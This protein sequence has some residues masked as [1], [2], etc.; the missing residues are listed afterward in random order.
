[1]ANTFYTDVQYFEDALVSF[2]DKLAPISALST[3]FEGEIQGASVIVPLASTG[4]GQEFAGTYA[5]DNSTLAEI[6][7]PVK[8]VFKSF[9]INVGDASK[10]AAASLKNLYKTNLD[11][12]MAAIQ[13]T[14]FADVSNFTAEEEFTTGAF[15]WADVKAA[16]T[17][18]ADLP[19][20]GKVL[21]LKSALNTQL[22]PNADDNIVVKA[23]DYDLSKFVSS[24]LPVDGVLTHA[25]TYAVATALPS[26]PLVG[27]TALIDSE[28]IEV[29]GM[30]I[31]YTVSGS[32]DTGTIRGTFAV[33]VGGKIAQD[34]SVNFVPAA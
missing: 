16:L 12:L 17:T 7:V 18:G 24:K 13:T 22:L 26:N 33:L 3:K 6:T 19:E 5:V 1:M 14:A 15:G 8:H 20:D 34:K 23:E 4:A 2:R 10:S 28:I 11:A 27:T 31:L 30:Q 9:S 29:D 32:G 21:I 25:G